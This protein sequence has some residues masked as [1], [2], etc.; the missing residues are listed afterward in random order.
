MDGELTKRFDH[1]ENLIDDL[2]V[3]TSKHFFP[4]TDK[5]DTIEENLV[6]LTG[7]IDG[8]QRAFYAGFAR[9]SALEARVSK[10]ETELH[11]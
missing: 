5:I 11:L 2:A 9:H 10:V 8:V 4:V 1:L 7:K 3:T 6:G